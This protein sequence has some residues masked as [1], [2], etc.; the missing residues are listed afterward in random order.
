MG[1]KIRILVAAGLLLTMALS[2]GAAD[3]LRFVSIRGFPPLGTAPSMQE[4]GVVQGEEFNKIK[5]QVEAIVATLTAHARWVAKDSTW[6]DVG[7]DAGYIS[8]V[9][10]LGGKTYTISSW[11]PGTQKS[12]TVAVSETNGLMAVKSP[13]EK[14]EIE[15]KN[16]AAYKQIVSVYDFMPKS[17]GR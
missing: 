8:A 11:Y 10:E 14:Q 6:W 9:I 2:A 16:S 5:P 13:D 12:S 3:R 4:L 17:P 15:S 1:M 7:P